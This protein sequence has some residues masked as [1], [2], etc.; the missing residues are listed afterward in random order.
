MKSRLEGRS[1]DN[2]LNMDQ[3]LIPFSYQSNMTLEVKG[4]RTVHSCASTTKTKRV[5]LAVTVMASGK[6]LALF[7]IFKGKPH[8][9][10]ALRNFGVSG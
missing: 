5:T 6:M 1:L 2:V 3:M 10:I 4:A 8:G 7:V 9:W